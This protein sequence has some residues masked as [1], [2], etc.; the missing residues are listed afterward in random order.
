MLPLTL[1]VFRD[2]QIPFTSGA[3]YIWDNVGDIAGGALFSFLLVYW[4]KPFKTIAITS[5]LLIVVSLLTLLRTR[6]TSIW[7]VALVPLVGIF[8]YL[9]LN[10]S[11]E[12]GSLSG[13]YGLIS[14]YE[15]SLYGR[16]VVTKEGRQHTF[17]DSGIPLYSEGDVIRAEEKSHYPLSQLEQ[18]GNVLLISGGLGE[19]I[20]EILKY[21]PKHIDYIELDPRLTQV[22]MKLN[23]VE[24]H[25][26][27]TIIN[28]DGRHYLKNMEKKY[29]AVLMDLPD[30]N[31]FQLNRFFTQE[32]FSLVKETL[33]K[34]GILSFRLSYSSNYISDIRRKK[35]SIVYATALQYFHNILVLPGEAVYFLCRN[36]RLWDDIP[37]RLAEKG[38]ETAYIAGSFS[39]N[40]TQDR[41]MKLRSLLDEEATV[42]TDFNPH[43]MNIVFKEWFFRH[44]QSPKAVVVVFM[45]LIGLYVLF[46]KRE[47]YV[48]FS[49]GLATMGAEMLVIFSF[50]VIYGYIYLEIGA[51]VTTFLLGL[52]PGSICG[53]TRRDKGARSLLV[54]D[55][56]LLFLLVLFFLWVAFIKSHFP[57]LV[58][59]A[60]SF[61]FAFFCG[62]QFPIAV[63]LMG[64]E[65]SPAATCL[66]A[67]LSGAAVGTMATGT[68]LIPLF[69]LQWGSIFL[70]IAKISSMIVLSG[71]IRKK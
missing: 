36:G 70:I 4:L 9:C 71:R 64:E 12:K 16:V 14:T 61:V 6:K 37:A 43:L 19:T 53:N 51:I 68:L 23:L 30:P 3:L 8:T 63:A 13:Q 42:N 39:G 27:L 54:S 20:E 5:A 57:P 44:G 24:D 26:L 67:D 32:F 55:M 69:G 46:M 33:T 21:Q 15:E 34:D 38:I 47:E 58:F 59:L 1:K 48:L 2:L 49:T 60:Y 17:W 22:A 35:L 18:V 29:D 66:A 7:I 10:S 56:I 28:T 45:I 11:F 52:L 31:T 62:Y 50:Q 41:I 25:P 65:K 40:V